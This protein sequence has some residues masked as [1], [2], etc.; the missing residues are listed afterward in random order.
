MNKNAAYFSGILTAIH[1]R[2]FK[3]SIFIQL[4]VE[5]QGLTLIFLAFRRQLVIS[6]P[7]RSW[8]SKISAKNK[9]PFY[10][11]RKC[12]LEFINRRMCSWNL[13]I[14]KLEFINRRV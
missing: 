14:E 13:Q 12:E 4:S 7:T 2:L 3:M 1:L 8:I 9:S 6:Y 5:C 10:R 11:N